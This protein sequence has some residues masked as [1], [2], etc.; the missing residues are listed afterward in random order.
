[1]FG[2][3]RILK[4]ELK[5]R[6]YYHFRAYYCGLCL[7][8]KKRSGQISRLLLNYDL[9]FLSLFL[10]SLNEAEEKAVPIR[11]PLHPFK[12]RPVLAENQWISY[13]ADLNVLLAYH[14]IED[15][16][17][18]NRTLS[19]LAGIKLLGS[20]YRQASLRQPETDRIICQN[21]KELAV[22]EKNRCRDIDAAAHPF[23]RI[24]ENICP[25][26]N[27]PPPRQKAIM[28]LGYNLGKWIYLI[29]ALDDIDEDIKKKNYNPFLYAYE[30]RNEGGTRFREKIKPQAEFLLVQ[31]LAQISKAWEV[32]D[33]RQ[34][35]GIIE[36][37]IYLGMLRQTENVINQRSCEKHEKILRNSW[38]AGECFPGRN[39]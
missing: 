13:A 18:D 15:N 35:R 9:T 37:I 30:Y 6:E 16:W 20:A 19:S 10:S 3:V 28:W 7:E 12:K 36:N 25:L 27:C 1:M 23:A 4:E 22:L 26:D 33:I 38:C 39:P 34:N 14:S 31:I 17:Q 24:V 8:L 29:D 32:L 5:I 2:Y 21:I 11:C